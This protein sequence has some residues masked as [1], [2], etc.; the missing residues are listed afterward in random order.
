[1]TPSAEAA[2]RRETQ[3]DSSA[4]KGK[5]EDS[6]RCTEVDGD[7]RLSSLKIE[8][9]AAA[10]PGTGLDPHITPQPGSGS[11]HDG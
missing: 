4:A 5:A 7:P 1:M 2:A 11:L 6:A 10:G 8:P 3:R 9:K